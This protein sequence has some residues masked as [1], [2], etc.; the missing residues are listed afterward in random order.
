M[1]QRKLKVG[2]NRAARI[3]DQIEAAGYVG[4]SNGQKP[5]EILKRRDV[6]NDE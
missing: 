4:P 3:L 2:Y 1:L 6:V 5:R